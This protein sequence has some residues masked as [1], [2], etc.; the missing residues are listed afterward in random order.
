MKARRKSDDLKVIIFH[1]LLIFEEVGKKIFTNRI[2][3]RREPFPPNEKLQRVV[4]ANKSNHFMWGIPLNR[5]VWWVIQWVKLV[6]HRKK[7]HWLSNEHTTHFFTNWSWPSL[8]HSRTMVCCFSRERRIFRLRLRAI[9]LSHSLSGWV[10]SVEVDIVKISI[11]FFFQL[12]VDI[13]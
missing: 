8:A 5:F 10:H 9:F 12:L 4:Q 11:L 2:A 1:V 7:N 6:E 3:R 13:L